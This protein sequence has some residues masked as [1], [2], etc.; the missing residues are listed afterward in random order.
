MK[1]VF[2][3]TI[4]IILLLEMICPIFVNAATLSINRLDGMKVDET[5]K[6]TISTD[7][8][9]SNMQFDLEFDNTKYEYVANSAKSALESTY[10]SLKGNNIVRVSSVDYDGRSTKTLTLEF[11]AI[12]TG[13]SVPFTIGGTVE[14]GENGEQLAEPT[15][16]V[17]KIEAAPKKDID[18]TS[19]INKDSKDNEYLNED[20]EAIKS[21]PQ[22]GNTNIGNIKSLGVYTRL[23]REEDKG[24]K[25]IVPY[26]LSNS[27]QRLS[28]NDIK[29]E[30]GEITTS[31]TNN[32]KTGDTFEKDGNKYTVIVYGDFNADGKITTLDALEIGK[33]ALNDATNAYTKEQIKAA[34]V[35]NN[36]EI[37]KQDAKVIQK[38]IVGNGTIIN[39]APSKIV[40][41][42]ENGT[43]AIT[44]NL[45]KTLYTKNTTMAK[46]YNGLLYTIIPMQLIDEKG[47]TAKI[48]NKDITTNATNNNIGTISILEKDYEN[49]TTGDISVKG[50]ISNNQGGYEINT[51]TFESIDAIGIAINTSTPNIPN[52]TVKDRLEKGLVIKYYDGIDNNGNLSS[53]S[54]TINIIVDE[55][56]PQVQTTT[57]EQ[58]ES[59]TLRKVQTKNSEQKQDKK[60]KSNEDK[61]EEEEEKNNTNTVNNADNNT[62][63]TNAN[64]PKTTVSE[65]PKIVEN[66]TSEE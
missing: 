52:L 39:N 35:E 57:S 40:G 46:Q 5:V 43:S 63:N 41:I 33:Y 66:K 64:V 59:Y 47:K 7:D 55:N 18:K 54:T 36:G 42:T 8:F 9:V 20:G 4:A 12:S 53:K 21:L 22:T 56:E 60:D 31:S 29:N 23:I 11:K 24:Y 50:F 14:L 34:D 17:S 13:E 27:D 61:I 45:S 26:A 1:K 32:I 62:A 3:K 28:V 51:G 16:K 15:I 37:T 44:G 25:L 6:V 2:L 30:F 65:E 38:F 48:L 49:L 19:D 10:S 58:S